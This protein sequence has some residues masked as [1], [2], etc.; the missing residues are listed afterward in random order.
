MTFLPGWRN[1]LPREMAALGLSRGQTRTMEKRCS[2]APLFFDRVVLQHPK[3]VVLCVLAAVVF[4]AFRA[5]GFRLDASAETLVL[6]HDE[7]L[8]YARLISSRYGQHDFLVLTYTPRS[9]LFSQESLATLARLRNDLASMEDVASV[10]SILDVPLLEN[11][12]RRAYATAFRTT[13]PICST[14]PARQTGAP[15]GGNLFLLVAKSWTAIDRPC[16]VTV[17]AP[18][19]SVRKM[20]ALAARK[21]SSVNGFGRFERPP[22][23]A[24]TTAT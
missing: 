17:T 24:V 19:R 21:R 4:L 16:R 20:R 3:T 8:Q 10:L 18:S 15:G 5:G 13:A 7:D 22:L 2:S 6:E 12:P 11:P 23:S 14:K 1:P 9:D